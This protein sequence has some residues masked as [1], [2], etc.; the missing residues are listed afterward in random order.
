M[1]HLS[2]KALDTFGKR[3][4]NLIL[5][6]ICIYVHVLSNINLLIVRLIPLTVGN[7]LYYRL[8]LNIF[9]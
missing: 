7:T 5:L 2:N 1:N 8:Y 3:I 6:I 9:I 4:G